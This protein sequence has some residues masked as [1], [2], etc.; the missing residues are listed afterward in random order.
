MLP[1]ATAVVRGGGEL[2]S[3]SARLLFLAGMRVVVLE[4]EK[5]LAVRRLVSFAEAVFSGERSVEGVRGVLLAIDAVPV[6]A[7]P[8]VP[9]VVDPDGRFLA[10]C[11]VDV[12]VDARMSKQVAAAR[13]GSSA[14]LIGLGPGFTAGAEVD[15]VIET[16]RG[17]GLGSVLWAGAAEPDTSLPSPVLGFTEKRV[18]R[19]PRTGTFR[20]RVGIGAIV[21]PG[22]VVGEVD[23]APVTTPIAG[24][25][26]GIVKDGVPVAAGT[27]VGDVDPRGPA[28]DAAQVS[29]KA[30]AVAAGVLEAILMR[31]QG[32]R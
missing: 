9:V 28:V 7:V 10:R 4:R 22:D 31:R 13:G 1:G 25:L 29:D 12:I 30:R 6:E 24:L 2:A 11:A 18:L 26:R 27:K 14:F 16:Q 19:A 17:P 21:I 3:A 15:A 5:P 20:E 23:G 8:F 32:L